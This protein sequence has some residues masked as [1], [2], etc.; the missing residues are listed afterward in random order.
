MTQFLTQDSLIPPYMAFPRFL[1]DK[2]GLSET[3]KFSIRFCSIEQDCH[4][5]MMDGRMNKVMCSFSFPSR[6]WQRSCTKAK[7]PLKLH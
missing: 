4:R 1:L 5:K 2:E 3:A 6:I 7:C